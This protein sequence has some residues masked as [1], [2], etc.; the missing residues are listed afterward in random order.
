MED[1]VVDSLRLESF[2][3]QIDLQTLG[4]DRADRNFLRASMHVLLLYV[5]ME[6]KTKQKKR[7]EKRGLSMES[8]VTTTFTMSSL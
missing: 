5:Y 1:T 2:V 7:K 4:R 6:R 8:V 3:V